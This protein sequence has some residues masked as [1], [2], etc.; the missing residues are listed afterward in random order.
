ML[1]AAMKLGGTSLDSARWVPK[2]AAVMDAVL[3]CLLGRALFGQLAGA[4]AG[5]LAASSSYLTGLGTTLFLDGSEVA[6]LLAALLTF[7]AAVESSSWRLHCLA[8]VLLGLAFLVKESA[9]L[10]LP[11]PVVF[12]LVAG[13]NR[14]WRS[15]VLAWAA[16]FAA[17]TGWWWAWVFAHEGWLYLFGAI[18]DPAAQRLLAVSAAAT[19]LAAVALW[20]ADPEPSAPASVW[21]RALGLAVVLG[22]GLL[23]IVGLER[24][25]W[26]STADYFSTVP[27]YF[28]D[29]L[30]PALRPWPLV[31]VAWGFVAWQ[32]M[33]SR[34]AHTLLFLPA[35][36][37][38]PFLLFAASRGLSLRDVLLVVYLSYVALGAAAAALVPWGQRLARDSGVEWPQAV[39]VAVVVA[40]VAATAAP[41]IGR[42]QG[43]EAVAL[44]DDWDNSVANET[45]AWL[46]SNAPEG[47]RV[48]STRLYYSQVYFLT[49]GRFPVYQ[50]PTVEVR[51]RGDDPTL[52]RRSTLFRW[53]NGRLPADSAED[54]WLYLTRYPLKGYY[55][56]LAEGDLLLDLRQRRVDYVIL[57]VLDAG[58]SSPSFAAYF[59]AN[60]AFHLA[61]QSRAGR[62]DSTRIYR[63][64]LQ[65]LHPSPARLQVTPAA[66]SGLAKLTGGEE[67]ANRLL[68][69]ANPSGFDLVDR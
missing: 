47:S 49:G 65:A 46:S 1:A 8:G 28:R 16:G 69:G 15:G 59:D 22:W 11:L 17:V 5:V 55:I 42:A 62:L 50:F 3:I 43:T 58:F 10:L 63:V 35:A 41:R 6:F 57:N 54:R 64:D 36:L 30:G 31:A 4:V 9:L 7:H 61:Y 18:A 27:A 53:E 29:V 2:L 25:N 37:F 67:V 51:P 14:G 56:G 20:R 40:M 48:M 34:Q 33:R 26:G 60:P 12:Y 13:R 24:S 68:L 66:Y 38:A 21:S 19:T 39:G 32:V 52:R 44:Q 45:A 23:F